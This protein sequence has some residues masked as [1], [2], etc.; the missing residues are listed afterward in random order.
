MVLLQL[1]VGLVQYVALS[2][3]QKAP[4]GADL[5]DGTTSHNFWPVFALPASAALVLSGR[6]RWRILWPVVVTLLAVYSEAKAALI[7]WLPIMALLLGAH[8]WQA[9]RR[10]RRRI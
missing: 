5:V 1:L 6:D 3:A 9:L 7:V 8:G 4:L 2:V 10:H